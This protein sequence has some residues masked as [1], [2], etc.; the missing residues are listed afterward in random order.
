MC[1]QYLFLITVSCGGTVGEFPTFEYFI[2]EKM[3]DV[4]A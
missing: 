2:S 4:D 1:L 3:F